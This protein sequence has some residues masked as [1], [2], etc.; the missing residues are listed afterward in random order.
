MDFWNVGEYEELDKTKLLINDLN[1]KNRSK[2]P[3]FKRASE[4]P[5]KKGDGH[6]D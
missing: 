2:E 5:K 6:A 3:L 1:R 4:A